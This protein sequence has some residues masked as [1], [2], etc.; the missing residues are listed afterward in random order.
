MV[1][2]FMLSMPS[3]ARGIAINP[4]ACAADDGWLRAS[5]IWATASWYPWDRELSFSIKM[6]G[7]LE[8]IRG[9][10]KSAAI[11]ASS[12]VISSSPGGLISF[13]P[14]A[15]RWEEGI[16]ITGPAESAFWQTG[17][18]HSC[19]HDVD[20]LRRI[21]VGTRLLGGILGEHAQG[22]ACL[23]LYRTDYPEA[24]EGRLLW[25]L[26]ARA[27]WA[28]EEV[29]ATGGIVLFAYKDGLG[30]D[31]LGRTGGFTRGQG[32]SFAGFL[33]YERAHDSGLYGKPKA[34]GHFGIGLG[35]WAKGVIF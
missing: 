32:A 21:L 16:L 3:P 26:G 28:S 27:S 22:F 14:L 12:E 2:A 5:G 19:K 7:F 24:R 6:G 13:H 23:Y 8:L 4:L 34:K 33:E 25:S 1:W 35:S 9:N 20:T 17:F 18:L 29:F 11:V 31:A 30:L 10:G 15:V